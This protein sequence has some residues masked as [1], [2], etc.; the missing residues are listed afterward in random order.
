MRLLS[1]KEWLEGY[2]EETHR[3]LLP[4]SAVRENRRIACIEFG[5]N[6]DVTLC[7][8]HISTTS[9]KY[10]DFLLARSNRTREEP[11]LPSHVI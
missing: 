7:R 6:V 2:G 8:L 4:T 3:L 11:G 1:A 9:K 5:A 10:S